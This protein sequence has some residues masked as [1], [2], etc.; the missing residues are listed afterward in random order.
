MRGVAPPDAAARTGENRP[1]NSLTG[2]IQKLSTRARA[3]RARQFRE[4]FT[5]TA[6]T[7]VLDLGS[8]SGAHIHSV[9]AGTPVRPENTYIA[10]IDK[11][12]LER[13]AKQYGFQPV[14]VGED[15]RR[16]F[17]MATSTSC[18]ARP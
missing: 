12:A 9:L 14:L 10:D 8:Q 15:G 7:T 6:D 3:R 5:L 17:P 18:T 1:T 11:A 4:A 2:L 13:G 16:R